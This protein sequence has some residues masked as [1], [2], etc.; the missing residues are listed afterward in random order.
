MRFSEHNAE[1]PL[2]IERVAFGGAGIGRLS[3]GKVCFVPRVI[4][5][6]EVLVRLR[7][8][9][10]SYVEANLTAVIK[11][12]PNRVKPKCP[13]Y[14]RCG[15]CHY[16]HLSY[17]R[18]LVLKTEQ[19]SEVLQR[20][21]GICPPGLRKPLIMVSESGILGNTQ[22]TGFALT[23]KDVRLLVYRFQ[24][25]RQPKGIE[26]SV[27]GWQLEGSLGVVAPA[28]ST[29]GS[30]IERA[31]QCARVKALLKLFLLNAVG[32][33]HVIGLRRHGRQSGL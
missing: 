2:V 27:P 30:L 6:E 11:A 19:V 26:R 32:S 8:S 12:S 25:S 23:L 31:K 24:T 17:E 18:Q 15:G 10:A 21:G 16:Q 3:N 20:L 29:A 28:D 9:Y 5:G 7:R 13:V 33:S 1:V 22:A 14:G 4:P